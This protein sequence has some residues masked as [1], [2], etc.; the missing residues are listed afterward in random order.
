MD[1]AELKQQLRLRRIV[2][3]ALNRHLCHWPLYISIILSVGTLLL[4]HKKVFLFLMNQSM[5]LFALSVSAVAIILTALGAILTL[6][7][8]KF[9]RFIIDHKSPK[10]NEAYLGFISP[11]VFGAWL[12]TVTGILFFG[13]NLFSIKPTYYPFWTMILMFSIMYSVLFIVYLFGEIIQHFVLSLF[14]EK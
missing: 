1:T 12:W 10:S 13:I 3:V 11:Y 8:K 4:N 7:P 14:I 5:S 2:K 9:L 6:Y